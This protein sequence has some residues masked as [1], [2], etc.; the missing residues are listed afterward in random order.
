MPQAFNGDGKPDVALANREDDQYFRPDC[1][2]THSI[3]ELSDDST[4]RH[5]RCFQILETDK[6]VGAGF[7]PAPPRKERK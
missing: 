4:R 2:L 6:T 1:M 7:F 5:Y 3:G